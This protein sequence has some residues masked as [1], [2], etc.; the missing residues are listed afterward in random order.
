MHPRGTERT[1]GFP[2]TSTCVFFF[3]RPISQHAH[4]CHLGAFFDESHRRSRE[5]DNVAAKLASQCGR[6]RLSFDGVAWDGSL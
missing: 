5:N 4:D 3:H 2:T 1:D 6:V